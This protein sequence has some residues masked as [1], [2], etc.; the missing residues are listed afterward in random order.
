MLERRRLSLATLLLIV[1]GGC[2]SGHTSGGDGPATVVDLTYSAGGAVKKQTLDC[3]SPA[4][5]DKP[6]CVLLGKL[7]SA[8]FKPVSKDQACTMIYGGPE[9]AT[10]KGTVRG[11]KVDARFSRVN[12]CEI[13]RWKQVE[14]LF[15]EMAG[16]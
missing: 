8:V 1:V 12:G 14:P 2:G 6:S 9:T 15:A 13:D 11:K 3:A 4:A 5:N 10:L 7:P 16:N